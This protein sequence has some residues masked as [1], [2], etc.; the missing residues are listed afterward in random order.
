MSTATIDFLKAHWE[1]IG[2][3]ATIAGTATVYVVKLL[4]ET[5]TNIATTAATLQSMQKDVETHDGEIEKVRETVGQHSVKIAVL[6]GHIG[7]PTT[8]ATH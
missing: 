8:R 3:I 6:E 5:S 2:T 7:V 4:W 1:V